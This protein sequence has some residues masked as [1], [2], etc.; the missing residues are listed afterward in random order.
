MSTT[1]DVQFVEGYNQ[2]VIDL[3]VKFP[4]LHDHKSFHEARVIVD[5]LAELY[6]VMYSFIDG[7]NQDIVE[8][9]VKMPVLH[10][11]SKYNEDYVTVVTLQS[12]YRCLYQMDKGSGPR[13]IPTGK[14]ASSSALPT[15]TTPVVGKGS[16]TAS[17]PVATVGA[18]AGKPILG[19]GARPKTSSA[20]G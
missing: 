7:G 16:S 11:F 5:K 20:A 15:P 18:P 4:L 1:H 6:A 3:P 14:T 2:Q 9:T 8:T 10:D 12:M 19:S 13:Q 17:R